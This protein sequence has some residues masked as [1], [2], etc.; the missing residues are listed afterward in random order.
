AGQYCERAQG[1]WQNC[2]GRQHPSIFQHH[3]PFRTFGKVRG[4][5]GKGPYPPGSYSFW[6]RTGAELLSQAGESLPT[7]VREFA[8]R[9]G[10]QILREQRFPPVRQRCQPGRISPIAQRIEHRLS[11]WPLRWW[12]VEHVAP[13]GQAQLRRDRLQPAAQDVAEPS[14]ERQHCQ[15]PEA[16]GCRSIRQGKALGRRQS[17]SQLAVNVHRLG[18]QSQNRRGPASPRQVRLESKFLATLLEGSVTTNRY[19]LGVER[20]TLRDTGCSTPRG[21]SLNACAPTRRGARLRSLPRR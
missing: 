6:G 4:E 15:S 10:C 17:F 18:Q 8:D 3:L 7:S 21:S 20:A 19:S 14:I 13:P 11:S 2:R 5:V 12:L 9:R 1:T 16:G